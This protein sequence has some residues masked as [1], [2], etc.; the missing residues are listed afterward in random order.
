MTWWWLRKITNSS[1]ASIQ[2]SL[3]RTQYIQAQRI[4][5][6]PSWEKSW[7]TTKT[8]FSKGVIG[9]LWLAP[10]NSALK[11]KPS[12]FWYC[13][14]SVHVFSIRVRL[15]Q[16]LKSGTKR[17]PVIPP[18]VVYQH[19]TVAKLATWVSN[20]LSGNLESAEVDEK[21]S[22]EALHLMIKKHLPCTIWIYFLLCL[23]AVGYLL[24]EAESFEPLH[25]VFKKCLPCP[26]CM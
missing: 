4:Y 3:Q 17:A 2:G 8:C 12:Y 24:D 26:I 14:A 18:Q 25:Q 16:L 10:S 13:L 6:R 1:S 7:K 15:S 20:V 11:L 23:A 9:Q 21:D 5:W 22:C 19:P